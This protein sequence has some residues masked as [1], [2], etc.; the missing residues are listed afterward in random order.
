MEGN[1]QNPNVTTL[2]TLIIS[3]IECI[4]P[5]PELSCR[6]PPRTRCRSK[7]RA[8]HLLLGSVA[9]TYRT[10]S[11]AI[12]IS[13]QNPTTM[14]KKRTKSEQDTKKDSDADA[15]SGKPA[16]NEHKHDNGHSRAATVVEA[17]GL[18]A[19]DK[20]W[21]RMGP[22]RIVRNLA[23]YRFILFGIIVHV[24]KRSE[25]INNQSPFKNYFSAQHFLFHF[26][27]GLCHIPAS[28]R[29]ASI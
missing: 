22:T 24:R 6:L 16:D 29:L 25:R 5:L 21:A 14:P 26:L 9:S 17:T 28:S 10:C 11:V 1:V 20:E 19:S 23:I 15:I 18:G 2:A 8:L 4:K 7:C 12:D 13:E 27:A 3:S